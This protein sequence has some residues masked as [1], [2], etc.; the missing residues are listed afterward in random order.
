MAL[1]AQRRDVFLIVLHQALIWMA[2]GL[3]AGLF[4]AAILSRLLT[5]QL[6]QVNPTDPFIYAFLTLLLLAVAIIATCIPATRATKVDP[7]I[8]LRYE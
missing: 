4:G 5:S 1:G 8:S 2:C 7:I 6:Y 3:I